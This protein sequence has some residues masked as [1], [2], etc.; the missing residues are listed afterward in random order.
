MN[1]PFSLCFLKKSNMTQYEQIPKGQKK[2]FLIRNI[3]CSNL[4]INLLINTVSFVFIFKC[5]GFC[6]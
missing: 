6:I 4:T 1:S 2:K 5:I 3:R